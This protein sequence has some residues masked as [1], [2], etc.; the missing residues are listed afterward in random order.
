MTDITQH[1]SLIDTLLERRNISDL[2]FLGLIRKA[3]NLQVHI[4]NNRKDYSAKRAVQ[5]YE[6]LITR[7]QNWLIVKKRISLKDSYNSIKDSF[8]SIV[9]L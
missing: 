5:G 2:T 6:G 1:R 7:R 8:L 4:R 9:F 3:L